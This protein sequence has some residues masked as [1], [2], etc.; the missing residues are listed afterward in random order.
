MSWSWQGMKWY[1]RFDK[2]SYD[3]YSPRL[4]VRE[5]HG[6]G[7]GTRCRAPIDTFFSSW[8]CRFGAVRGDVAHPLTDVLSL[9]G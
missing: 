3:K 6:L 5:R 2:S 1:E 4:T 7:R 8:G 9:I